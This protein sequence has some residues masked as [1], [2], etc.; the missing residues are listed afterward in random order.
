MLINQYALISQATG[1]ER[2]TLEL[3]FRDSLI[4]TLNY[5]G[6]PNFPFDSLK[7][8]GRILSDDEKLIVYSWNIPQSGGFNNYYCLLQ[9]FNKKEKKYTLTT[10]EEK[11]G[12]LNQDQQQVASI[13]LW[14]GALYYQ[15]ITTKYKGQNF[16][17][18]LGFDFNSLISNRKLIEMIYF[19]EQGFPH[20]SQQSFEYEGKM[21][22]RIVFEYAERAQMN[23]NYNDNNEMIVFD[24]LS[25]FKPSLQ[26]QYQFYGPD[27]SYD[28]L[29]F[30]ERFWVHESDIVP[31]F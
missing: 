25:P 19:D 23:V 30:K 13:N 14:P 18:L 11:P 15:I 24:H 20:F 8:I 28:G 17:T 27:M 2:K 5:E 3:N 6:A 31:E 1:K 9:F 12:F 4:K 21:L 26:D 7:V 22:N 29:V 16:Y 10:L